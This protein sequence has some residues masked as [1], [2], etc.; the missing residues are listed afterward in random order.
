MKHSN[1]LW[2]S[3]SAL[4]EESVADGWWENTLFNEK[5]V[6]MFGFVRL[7]SFLFGAVLPLVWVRIPARSQ[8]TGEEETS[9]VL[10]EY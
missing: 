2:L 7:A 1:T 10:V 9:F 5:Y 6:K 4:N 8:D 3:A